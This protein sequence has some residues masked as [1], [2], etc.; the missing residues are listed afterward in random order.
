M[1]EIQKNMGEGF[2]KFKRISAIKKI[3]KKKYV[4]K[5]LNVKKDLDCKQYLKKQIIT[6]DSHS[7][8]IL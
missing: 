8:G 1:E 6:D 3:K 2:L 4:Y 5:I 7:P